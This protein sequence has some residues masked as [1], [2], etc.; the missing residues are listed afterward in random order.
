MR[1]TWSLLVIA[2]VC[3]A[4]LKVLNPTQLS[5]SLGSNGQIQSS[6]ANFGHITYGQNLIGK[7]LRPRKENATGCKAFTLADFPGNF[8]LDPV[9]VG[10]PR[11][12]LMPHNTFI[13]LE[14]GHCSNP[15][16]VRN[17]EAFGASLA[18]IGDERDEDVT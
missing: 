3:H 1:L 4:G 14:R 9:M 16:K 12:R 11:V 13:L 8:E 15:T 5:E 6:L 10:M 18:L 7:V 2:Q 17:V